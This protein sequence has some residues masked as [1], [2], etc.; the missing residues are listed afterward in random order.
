MRRGSS[1]WIGFGIVLL[2]FSQ[3]RPY[4]V[5][6]EL[7]RVWNRD[8]DLDQ[9][10]QAGG[11][12]MAVRELRVAWSADIVVISGRTSRLLVEATFMSTPIVADVD[13]GSYRSSQYRM[14]TITAL[15]VV[16]N[17]CVVCT[18]YARSFLHLRDR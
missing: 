1:W 3:L 4:Q 18:T 10:C 2:S 14:R 12:C 9:R 17:H 6:I 13:S 11:A 16:S 7:L 8:T 15:S 5:Q